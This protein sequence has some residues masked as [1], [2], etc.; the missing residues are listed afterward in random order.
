MEAFGFFLFARPQAAPLAFWL[1]V[2]G[3]CVL[4][5]D[6]VDFSVGFDSS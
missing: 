4:P 1:R 5:S 3:L 6:D 2:C